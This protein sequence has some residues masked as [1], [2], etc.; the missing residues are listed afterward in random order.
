VF[1]NAVPVY[2]VSLASI[3]KLEHQSRVMRWTIVA[4][5]P[6]ASAGMLDLLPLGI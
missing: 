1:Q 6:V 5:V 4:D 2:F 3:Q